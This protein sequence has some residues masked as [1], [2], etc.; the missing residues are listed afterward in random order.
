MVSFSATVAVDRNLIMFSCRN[1]TCIFAIPYSPLSQQLYLTST[2]L[3]HYFWRCLGCAIQ[4]SDHSC[5]SS[6]ACNLAISVFLHQFH[7]SLSPSYLRLSTGILAPWNCYI[8]S[9]V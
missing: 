9:F 5:I 1:L 7:T 4:L 8:K 3:L 6:M 2:T